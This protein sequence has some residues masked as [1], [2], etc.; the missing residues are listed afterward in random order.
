MTT[1][2]NINYPFRATSSRAVANFYIQSLQQL[3]L[4][5]LANA[6]PTQSQNKQM[7]TH[8]QTHTQAQGRHLHRVCTVIV[9]VGT[10]ISCLRRLI[11]GRTLRR[12]RS[13]CVS[14]RHAFLTR[15]NCRARLCHH[16]DGASLISGS[17][18]F[19]A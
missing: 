6:Q 19:C 16:C 13:F 15:H 7:N 1:T 18:C 14:T 11:S 17:K 4:G 2:S 5:V 9:A 8:T 12:R 10:N 3:P